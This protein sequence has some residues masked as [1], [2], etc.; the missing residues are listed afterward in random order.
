MTAHHVL[1]QGRLHLYQRGG[2]RWQCSTYLDGRNHRVSTKE[3]SLDRAKDF[4]EDWFLTLKGKHRLGIKVGEKTF[5]EAA[6]KFLR[7]Y[8]A[9][10]EGR[11]NAQYVD[12]HERRLRIHLIPF[13]GRMG[14]SQIT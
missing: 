11:R 5:R 9:I 1:M 6:E 2:K 8:K 12:G 4:A 3:E 10:T 13:F 7:E 14:L